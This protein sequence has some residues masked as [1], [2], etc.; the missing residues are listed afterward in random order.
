M[1]I[2]ISDTTFASVALLVGSASFRFWM[3]GAMKKGAK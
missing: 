2:K 3:N 1:S